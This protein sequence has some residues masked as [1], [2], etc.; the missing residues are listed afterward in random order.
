MN[1]TE[2]LERLDFIEFRQRLL[3]DN[4]DLDRLFFE[5]EI[6]RK[7]S[8]E[9]LN[10]FASM[11]K[12]LEENNELSDMRYESDIYEIVPHLKGDYHF[13]EFVA[14]HLHEDGRYQEVFEAL[15]SDNPK[16]KTYLQK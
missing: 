15:Y 12:S 3:F 16:Y 13:A 5:Y 8:K 10:L 7:Q 6:T 2:L 11:R 14:K 9:I 1:E 4:T